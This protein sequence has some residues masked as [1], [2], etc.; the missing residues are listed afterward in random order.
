MAYNAAHIEQHRERQRRYN[1]T[2]ERKENYRKYRQQNRDRCRVNDQ[3]KRAR[4][5][6]AMSGSPGVTPLQWAQI[7]TKHRNCCAYCG[8]KRPLTMDH[9]T[10][11]ARGGKHEPD[12]IAPACR[13]CNSRKHATDPIE[14]ANRIGRLL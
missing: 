13:P 9:I 12:N 6:H 3:N 4:R 7:K 1:A 2:P 11:L 14:Y 5:K 10:P 8:K